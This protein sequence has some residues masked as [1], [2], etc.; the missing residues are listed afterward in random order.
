MPKQYPIVASLL[1]ILSLGACVGATPGSSPVGTPRPL[2][3]DTASPTAVWQ[4]PLAEGTGP[5]PTATGSELRALVSSSN[6]FAFALD[7]EI[8][9]GADNLC[10]SPYGTAQMLAMAYAGAQGETATQIAKATGFSLPPDR[11]AAAFTALRV[12]LSAPAGSGTTAGTGAPAVDLSSALWAQGDFRFTPTFLDVLTRGLGADLQPVDFAKDPEQVR[13]TI[14]AWA[15]GGSDG[16][17]QEMLEQGSVDAPTRMVLTT[18]ASLHAPWQ[19]PFEAGETGPGDFRLLD[20]SKIQ[21]AMMH[22][23]TKLPVAQGE[24]FQA[25]ELQYAGGSL[26]MLVIVPEEGHFAEVGNRLGPQLLAD[27]LNALQPESVDLAFPKFAFD[28]VISLPAALQALGMDDAFRATQAD[29]SGMDGKRDLYI[30]EMMHKTSIQVDEQGSGV[31]AVTAVSLE[32]SL[33]SPAS[34]QLNVERPF[35]FFV[36]DKRTGALLFMGRLTQ[37]EP[38]S[39]R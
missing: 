15:L 37:P 13:K 36:R 8:S 1:L 31:H 2:P 5:F 20:G 21:V 27:T 35:F 17:I 25:F 9:S 33:R 38:L 24:S 6:Q 34:L 32:R 12:E 16:A 19:V 3:T 39:V 11:L 29:F 14:N 10:F 7:T 23:E 30:S 18:L 26:S 28:D 22:L 4:T